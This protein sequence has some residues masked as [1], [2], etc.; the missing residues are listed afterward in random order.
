MTRIASE[1]TEMKVGAGTLTEVKHIQQCREAGALFGLSPGATAS[2]LAAA[3]DSGWPFIPGVAT[4]SELMTAMDH[5]FTRLK[6]FPA[7][8]S[9]G[10][11]TL[12]SLGGPFPQATFCPTG[13]VNPG[14]LKSYL[15]LSNVACVG[16]TWLTPAEL[17]AQKN[18]RGI[19]SLTAESI[20]ACRDL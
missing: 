10:V 20:A 16:G 18:W 1:L 2:L 8:A 3:R 15:A 4:A 14:N 13:G 6:F 7:E 19:A 12:K 5:G 17:V 9:G 11:S